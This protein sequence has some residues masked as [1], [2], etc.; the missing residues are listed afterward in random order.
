ML[1][2]ISKNELLS[3]AIS[4]VDRSHC[5]GEKKLVVKQ[6]MWNG[7]MYIDIYSENTYKNK[8]N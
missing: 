6:N 8:M 4:C 5:T 3:Q 1:S 2:V 7:P